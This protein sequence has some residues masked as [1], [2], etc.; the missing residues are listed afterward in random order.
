MTELEQVQALIAETKAL[1]LSKQNR[2]TLE[3]RLAS[4]TAKES[5]LTAALP[6]AR[7]PGL[8]GVVDKII[9]DANKQAP[10]HPPTIDELP[11]EIQA[12]VPEV[13]RRK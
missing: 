5:E 13:A 11:P 1:L 6:P 10:L 3:S 2:E 9:A 12:L 4:L 8:L 7:R